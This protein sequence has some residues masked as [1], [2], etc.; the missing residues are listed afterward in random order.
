MRGWLCLCEY[1]LR[2][3]L[4]HARSEVAGVA[5]SRIV[6]QHAPPDAAAL[7]GHR[8][9]TRLRHTAAQSRH[10]AVCGPC[11][12]LPCQQMQTQLHMLQHPLRRHMSRSPNK[13][14]RR[15]YRE[16]HQHWILCTQGRRRCMMTMDLAQIPMSPVTSMWC[17][18]SATRRA[19][20]PSGAKSSICRHSPVRS[21]SRR[22]ASPPSAAAPRPDPPAA[23]ADVLPASRASATVTYAEHRVVE[24]M[25]A[26][27]LA[28]QQRAARVP[29]EATDEGL[30]A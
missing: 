24:M 10:I 20:C 2:V 1:S 18:D 14:A 22:L 6:P 23:A 28:C 4:E 30:H 12:R 11:T 29:C 5:Q 27:F 21:S 25:T 19:C 3:H 15:K 26:G 13:P 17:T 8:T 9:V 16:K 7:P